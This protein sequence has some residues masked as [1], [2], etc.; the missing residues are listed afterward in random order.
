M[1]VM[2]LIGISDDCPLKAGRERQKGWLTFEIIT[3]DEYLD[4]SREVRK[5]H[6]PKE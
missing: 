6:L 1:P 5:E 4:R 2:R 3:P